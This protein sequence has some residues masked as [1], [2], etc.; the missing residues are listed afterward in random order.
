MSQAPDLEALRAAVL[1][2]RKQPASSTTLTSA[3]DLTS[4]SAPPLASVATAATIWTSSDASNDLVVGSTS[5]MPAISALQQRQRAHPSIDRE[6]G[7]ISDD[8]GQHKKQQSKASTGFNYQNMASK[9]MPLP[10]PTPMPIST[11]KTFQPTYTTS[12]P[13]NHQPQQDQLISPLSKTPTTSSRA[14]KDLEYNTQNQDFSTLIEEYQLQKSRSGIQERPS[15]P[16]GQ[17]AENFDIPGLGQVRSR[18]R[19]HIQSE[20][21]TRWR[22]GATIRPSESTR[23]RRRREARGSRDLKRQQQEAS[24]ESMETHFQ[25]DRSS[26]QPH[27]L[28]SP[29]HASFTLRHEQ[30]APP[31]DVS[32]PGAN[33]NGAT[34]DLAMGLTAGQPASQYR[35][36]YDLVNQLLDHGISPHLLF[37]MSI[38]PAIINDVL[39]QRQ[40]NY[41]STPAIATSYSFHTASTTS[42]AAIAPHPFQHSHILPAQHTPQSFTQMSQS[43]PVSVHAVQGSLAQGHPMQMLQLQHF[44]QHLAPSPEGNVSVTPSLANQIMEIA[45]QLSPSQWDQLCRLYNPGSSGNLDSTNVATDLTTATPAQQHTHLSHIDPPRNDVTEKPMQSARTIKLEEVDDGPSLLARKPGSNEGARLGTLQTWNH[46]VEANY[47]ADKFNG[48]SIS[49]DGALSGSTV[50]A[51]ASNAAALGSQTD[52]THQETKAITKPEPL[53]EGTLMNVADNLQHQTQTLVKPG[54]QQSNPC[55]KPMNIETNRQNNSIASRRP[56]SS[57]SPPPPPPPPPPPVARSTPPPPPPPSH[58]PNDMPVEAVQSPSAVS[59]ASESLGN[60]PHESS[61]KDSAPSEE[62]AQGSEAIES[63]APSQDDMDME[64]DDDDFA[65][66]TILKGSWKTTEEGVSIRTSMP[67]RAAPKEQVHPQLRRMNNAQRPEAHSAPASLPST[68]TRSLDYGDLSSTTAMIRP[69]RNGRRATALDFMKTQQPP[70]FISVRSLPY[71]IDLDDEDGDELGG[72]PVTGNTPASGSRLVSTTGNNDLTSLERQVK[73]M[74]NRIRLMEMAKLSS[75]STPP[76]NSITPTQPAL[77]GVPQPTAKSNLV[78]SE[79]RTSVVDQTSNMDLEGHTDQESKEERVQLTGVLSEH[80]KTLEQL[81]SQLQ[82]CEQEKAAATCSLDTEMTRVVND[83]QSLEKLQQTLHQA[84]E[85][86][87]SKRRELEEAQ[88][89][90]DET[91]GLVTPIMSRLSAIEPR[92]KNLRDRIEAANQKSIELKASIASLQQDIIRKR[93]RLVLLE[94]T[95][96][97]TLS[98]DIEKVSQTPTTESSRVTNDDAGSKRAMDSDEQQDAPLTTKKPRTKSHELSALTKR[99]LE[100]T[101]ESET[102]RSGSTPAAPQNGPLANSK[103]TGPAAPRSST[104]NMDKPSATSI[105]HLMS[106]ASSPLPMQQATRHGAASVTKSNRPSRK[107]PLP[108]LDKFLS[109]A[110]NLTMNAAT[111]ATMSMDS[112][113]TAWRPSPEIKKIIVS[114]TYAFELDQLCTPSAV[115]SYTIPSPRAGQRNDISH[116]S[117][118]EASDADSKGNISHYV[119]P[120]TMFRSFRFSS[121]FKRTVRDGYR[122]LSFSHKIDPMKRMC[123]YELSGGSCNDDT[124]MSQHL[125]DCG[126]TDEELVIDMAR[127]SEGSTPESRKD[128]VEKQSEKLAH[129][130][131]SGIHNAELL[132]DSIVKNHRNFI[133]YHTQAIK[134]G[135]RIVIQGE[136]PK[137][138]LV[139]NKKNIGGARAMD[140]LYGQYLNDTSALDECPII[141]A[142]LTQ[143]LS[144]QHS[145]K[146][147]RR[148]NYSSTEDYEKMVENSGADEALWI[149]YAM[150]HLSSA[151][152]D[153]SE[154]AEARSVYEAMLV[155]SRAI[156]QIPD[157]ECLWSLYMDLHSCQGNEVETRQMFE[158]GLL[159]VPDAQLLWFRYYLWEKG[160]FERACILDRMMRKACQAP[161]A[162]DDATIRS[163]FILDVV[164]QIVKCLVSA[165]FVESSKNWMQTFLT[166]TTLD[167][168]QDS[169]LLYN[170]MDGIWDEQDMVEDMSAT[171]ASKWLTS[172]DLC[173]LW[174]AYVYLIWF[175]ELPTSLFLDYPNTYTSD[176]ALFVIQ[177]PATAEP[178]EENELH[179]IVH[180]IFLG[181]TMYFVDA[182]ARPSL[183]ATLKN[184]VGF[185]I[186]RGQMQHEILELVNPT[187][188][189]EL[190]P[191]VQDLFCQVKMHFGEYEDVKNVF[192]QALLES[193]TQPYLW[194]R[195]AQMLPGEGRTACLEQCAYEFFHVE[196]KHEANIGRSELSLILYR[197]LLGLALPY[198][199]EVPSAKQDIAPF[200]ADICLWLNYLSLLAMH[201]LPGGSFAHLESAFSS[202]LDALE[203]DSKTIILIEFAV[204]SIMSNLDKILEAGG[205]SSAAISVLGEIRTSRPNPYEHSLIEE[206]KVMPLNDFNTLNRVIEKV[207]DLTSQNPNELHVELVDAFLRLFPDD[208]DLYLWMGDAEEANGNE[209]QCRKILVVCLQ[210]FPFSDY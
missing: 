30:S 90:L 32:F 113:P 48:L 67:T 112:S 1:L 127:Y 64:L 66:S 43:T 50:Q 208:P 53:L 132:V 76:G 207:W 52:N 210:R 4:S 6:E 205:F 3:S 86:V 184:F 7:E 156:S 176:S 19:P 120:L 152:D 104:I 38:E 102:L 71:L 41:T 37:K 69:Q 58:P 123:L 77:R 80:S 81:R 10:A 65:E 31:A 146:N 162:E 196:T 201:S 143:T 160:L 75:P 168:I 172:K 8:E 142:S 197:K 96:A 173:V 94:S 95:S 45:S 34:Q 187:Q 82:A 93:T 14:N 15:V 188:F 24:M 153:K 92:K 198:V 181:L 63:L 36:V 99:M 28:Q 131:A 154:D 105:P 13:L 139:V 61:N 199:F 39:L 125:R 85:N 191:E 68:P 51:L 18:G 27:D 169:S 137:E 204:H 98:A 170:Q 179:T 138:P 26:M 11:P 151:M 55:V 175:H 47:A 54:Y 23:A 177:W 59:F 46:S 185:L 111:G 72:A 103:P 145:S 189:P 44:Q 192:Q 5:Q 186:A 84:K 135:E 206:A 9:P 202:A 134:F 161:R 40:S 107:N 124:C 29:R 163:Q 117:V 49:T 195:Y 21:D 91:E 20:P 89:H 190:F 155:L 73:A 25:R 136:P 87:I 2:S 35:Q 16:P 118:K 193:P 62:D 150:S 56:Y 140:R 109:Q 115:L 178:E 97:G 200:K 116:A 128:F 88:R 133:K 83:Q 167:E 122:S 165:G 60:S 100:L 171:L 17:H 159:H 78:T 119:S 126:L 164:L 194:N 183:V 114:N 106:P 57:P 130:R 70:P 129:L 22:P 209:D 121:R 158:R 166:C 157:S 79:T 12:V 141:M 147:R 42:N 148:Q 149:E 101:K 182:D 180:E 203:G 144:R 174:L 110:K 108:A 33:W 74:Q